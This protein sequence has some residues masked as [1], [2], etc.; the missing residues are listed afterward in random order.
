MTQRVTGSLVLSKIHK[1][2]KYIKAVK[3]L[4][5]SGPFSWPTL[6]FFTQAA[7]A[8]TDSSGLHSSYG[9]CKSVTNLQYD[10]GRSKGLLVNEK[11]NFK[12]KPRRRGGEV[13]VVC[14]MHSSDSYFKSFFSNVFGKTLFFIPFLCCS[15][16]NILFLFFCFVLAHLRLFYH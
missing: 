7:T 6:V 8:G 3:T 2:Y 15:Y 12:E 4:I 13:G 9:L 5:F 14:C 16:Y 1:Y 11:N 10:Q